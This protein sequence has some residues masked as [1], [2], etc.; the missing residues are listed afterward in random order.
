M[1]GVGAT[2]VADLSGL[3]SAS[4]LSVAELAAEVQPAHDP[5]PVCELLLCGPSNLKA[6]MYSISSPV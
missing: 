2:A 1:S 4:G 6:L 3:A 5:L